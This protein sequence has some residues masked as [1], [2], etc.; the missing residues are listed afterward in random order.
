MQPRR[1]QCRKR[2]E[3]AGENVKVYL[4][5]VR[6]PENADPVLGR[7]VVFATFAATEEESLLDVTGVL[8]PGWHS[9]EVIGEATIRFAS[10]LLLEPGKV[11]M[12]EE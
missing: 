1:L 6:T 4:V 2:R 11:Q 10:T 5:R 12:L 3:P 8:E 7:W 9:A